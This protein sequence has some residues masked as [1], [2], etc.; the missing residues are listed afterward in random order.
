M[1]TLEF[2]NY[3]DSDIPWYCPSCSSLN[4][5]TIVYDLPEADDTHSSLNSSAMINSTR[6]STTADSVSS[7]TSSQTS[8]ADI[9]DT[10]FSSLGSPTTASS[11][12]PTHATKR[13]RNSNSLRFLCINFQ[14]AKKKAKHISTLIECT[15]PD[16][17]IGTETWLS[18]DVNSSEIFEESLGFDVHRNDRPD[19]P[20]GGVLLAVRKE[21]NVTDVKRSSTVEMITGSIKTKTKRKIII[22]S[23]YR[24]PSRT[25]ETYL[26]NTRSELLQL[27]ADNKRAI[28]V[29]GG[30]FNLPDI[31]WKDN[32]IPT[33]RNYPKRVNQHFLDIASDLGLE[34]MVNF[35]TRKDNTLDLILT[36]HP[37]YTE[38]CKPL[39]PVTDKSDHDIVLYDLAMQAVRT[40]P[41]RRT[42]YLWNKADTEGIKKALASFGISFMKQTF[43]SVE[44]MWQDFKAAISRVTQEYVPTRRTL[45]RQTH[46]WID[47]HLRKLTRRKYRAHKKAKQTGNPTD[48]SRYNRL[49]TQVQKDI[50]QSHRRYMT[51]IISTSYKERP[52]QFWSYIKSRKQEAVGIAPLKNRDGFIHSDSKAKAEILNDQFRSVFTEEDTTTMPDKGPSPHPTMADITIQSKGVRKQL[53]GLN[54]HKASGPD[55]ISNA[56]LKIAADELAPVLTR[57]YQQSLDSGEVPSDWREALVVPVFKKG[58]KHLPSNYRPVSLTSVV[59]KVL[60]HIVYSSVMRFFE[61]HTILTDT[62]HGFRARRSC[63]TQLLWT[64]QT[65]A[66]KLKGRGQVDVILL[67]F[68]KAFDKVPHRRLLHK[69]QYYGIRGSTLGWIGSFLA[70]RKQ[71]VLLEGEKSSVADVAS[72]V[73]QG[74]VLGPLLFLA[75]IN[76]LP[77]CVTSSESRLFAD[78]S[79]LFRFIQD[80]QDADLLQKDLTALEKWESDWQM[81]FHP[82]KCTVLRICNNK[83]HRIPTTY[84]LHGHTLETADNCKYLGVTVSDDLSWKKHIQATATKGNRTLGFIRR[85]LTGCTTTVKAAAYT[86]IIRPTLEYASTVWDPA[87][88]AEAHILE[89]VQRKAARFTTNSYTD[90]SPGCVTQMIHTLGWEPLQHRR[91]IARIAMLFKIHNNLVVVPESPLIQSDHRTRGANRFFQMQATN[92]IHRQSFFP[93]TIGDWNRL[94]ARTT[95]CQT[96]EGFRAEIG[97]LPARH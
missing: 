65:I 79:L 6:S 15:R 28:F 45:A 2:N 63:E 23:Y 14:S 58:E 24:P 95:N 7:P 83:R 43:S 62:Q 73:P 70:N 26:Q 56:I 89:Q 77:D 13:G 57:L 9:S 36:S 85:N 84:Q 92:N 41:K 94:P 93:R 69:L 76:D 37:S 48:W 33:T 3:A 74:T 8:S 42:I 66:S 38:R 53:A 46:P 50:R 34:Q 17:I 10:T 49:K 97:S 54:A 39:P 87:T 86:T 18:S 82:E 30:D 78:D 32:S 67:D 35:A 20:H 88:S 25:D 61:D 55:G 16:V 96:L 47:G 1:N 91:Y 31:C 75:Y 90:R 4:R 40:H 44:A 52:K 68:A 51:N 5:T 81:K 60:E 59:C 11:P 22:G 72:G 64:I 21:L 19:N 27:K 12:K 71:Q 80:Q 29:L